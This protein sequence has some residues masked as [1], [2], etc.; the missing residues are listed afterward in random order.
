MNK[1]MKTGM[2]VA[3]FRET[4]VSFLFKHDTMSALYMH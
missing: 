3:Y 1:A 4:G 2:C